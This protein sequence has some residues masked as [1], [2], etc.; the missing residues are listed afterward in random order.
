MDYVYGLNKSGQSIVKLLKKNK[1]KYRYWDDDYNVRKKIN[2][3]SNKELF[4]PPSKENLSLFDNIYVSPGI[5]IRTNK[6]RNK[7][8]KHKVKRDTNLYLSNLGK[9]KIIAITGTNG[10][11]TTTKLIGDI[12]KKN[13]KKTFVGGNI[14]NPLCNSLSNNNYFNYHVIELS[15]FQLETINNINSKISIITNLS[16]D[17]GDRYRNVQDYI[18]QKKNILTI[19]GFNLI[20]I[21]DQYSKKIFYTNNNIKKISFSI[22]DSSADIFF[23]NTFIVD[24]F[25]HKHKFIYIEKISK[26]LN[27]DFKKQNIIIAYICSKILKIK[28]NNFLEVV[29]TFKGLPYRSKVIYNNKKCTIVNNSK[30]TNLNSTINSIK[31]YENILLILGGKAKEDNFSKLIK[32][33]NKIICTYVYGES[34]SKIN[35]SINKQINT[36]KFHTIDQLVFQLFKDIKLYNTKVTILFAP[37]C[38]SYDQFINFEQRGFYFTKIIKKLTKVL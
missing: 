34:A 28:K 24:K 17:H 30:S 5:T 4:I 32:F 7:Y 20:S 1:V 19:K 18:L 14:G 38:S 31:S 13:N 12:L 15:S 37:A 9:E 16:N 8:I 22:L 2:K 36:K 29:S 11:S 3:N 33:K 10:K 25:F 26:D 35:K 21:D 23:D 6:F 27:G